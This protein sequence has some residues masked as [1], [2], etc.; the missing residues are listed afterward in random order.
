[1]GVFEDYLFNGPFQWHFPIGVAWWL[2]DSQACPSELMVVKNGLL[3]ALCLLLWCWGL[4]PRPSLAISALSGWLIG[5]GVYPRNGRLFPQGVDCLH[6]ATWFVSVCTWVC[7][8]PQKENSD[9]QGQAVFLYP[10]VKTLFRWQRIGI[11]ISLNR[12]SSPHLIVS[13]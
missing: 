7:I 1:M 9:T 4:V 6:S 3:Q 12:L 5:A 2:S 8:N 13:S 11:V 10:L